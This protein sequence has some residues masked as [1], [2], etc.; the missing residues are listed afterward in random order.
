MTGT[1]SAGSP[2]VADDDIQIGSY[3]N[4]SSEPSGVTANTMKATIL[5]AIN[6]HNWFRFKV[7][8]SGTSAV[9]YYKM[10][11]D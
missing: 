5:A 6:N 10:K 2:S 3:N 8:V 9:K 11:F 1:Y 7:T 4:V